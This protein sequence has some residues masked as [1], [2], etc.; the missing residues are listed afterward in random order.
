MHFAALKKNSDIMFLLLERFLVGTL[1]DINAKTLIQGNSVLHIASLYKDMKTVELLLDRRFLPYVFINIQNHDHKIPLWLAAEIGHSG[2]CKLLIEK[3][4]ATE[5][6]SKEKGVRNRT[7][8]V[9]INGE[10]SNVINHA[11]Y[12]SLV[13]ILNKAIVKMGGNHVIYR[14][15]VP[16]PIDYENKNRIRDLVR[17]PLDDYYVG[18]FGDD[19]P[20]IIP[21]TNTTYNIIMTKAVSIFSSSKQ[22]LSTTIDIIIAWSIPTLN[23]VIIGL[24][25]S[26]I[27]VISIITIALII[28]I[29]MIRK[30]FTSKKTRVKTK[31]E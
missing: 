10:S 30:I 13:P 22:L 20:K 23:N 25:S 18:I 8:K 28:I 19:N 16:L 27:T 3:G 29:V 9:L 15:H 21:Y 1:L 5:I 7:P 6:K 17:N 12:S 14:D 26:N 24:S 4:S 31:R 2:I 11:N